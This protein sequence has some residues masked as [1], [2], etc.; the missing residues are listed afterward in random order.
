MSQVSIPQEA[1][2][3]F[4][5]VTSSV[6]EAFTTPAPSPEESVNENAS[7]EPS[8]EESTEE[9]S[10]E[11]PSAEEIKEW[12]RISVK[13]DKRTREYE[14]NPD[15]IELQKA[16]SMG[17]VAPRFLKERNEARRTL[18]E[19]DAAIEALQEKASVWDNLQEL[20]DKGFDEHVAKAVLGEDRWQR[21]LEKTLKYSANYDDASPE[22]RWQMDNQRREEAQ[23]WRDYQS[24]QE[25][26]KYEQKLQAMEDKAEEDRI[27]SAA[28]NYLQKV[29][30]HNYI[31]N[32]DLADDLNN[33]VWELAMADLSRLADRGES[34]SE[35]AIKKAIFRRAKTLRAG[36]KRA[37]KS[38]V[39]QMVDKKKADAKAKAGV[40]ATKSLPKNEDLSG[41]GPR[42]LFNKMFGR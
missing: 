36:H 16:L 18:K 27:R 24:D 4:A 5:D 33:S 25:R 10:A 2:N 39:R 34:L 23:K 9:T 30:F 7:Q 14:L 42:D 32:A 40:A 35:D 26:S 6:E 12:A 8:F 29:D 20:A 37:A 21:L 28:T 3:D 1:G 22:E 11:Q 13:G 38:Q 31:D 15:N 41:L 19:R 17:A